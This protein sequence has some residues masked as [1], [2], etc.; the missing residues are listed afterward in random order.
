MRLPFNIDTQIN[1][2]Q[3]EAFVSGIILAED[4]LNMPYILSNYIRTVHYIDSPTVLNYYMD[5]LL[6]KNNGVINENLTVLPMQC[7][8]K[9]DLSAIAVKALNSGR[10]V[11]GSF[12][13]ER[14]PGKSSYSKRYFIHDYLLY[15]YENEA[16]ISSAYLSDGHYREFK[17][18]F[19]DYNRAMLTK[20]HGL[21]MHLLYYNRNIEY[22]FMEEYVIEAI[23]D[24]ITSKPLTDDGTIYGLQGIRLFADEIEKQGGYLDIRS[25]CFLNE[26]K[27][28]MRLRLSYMKEKCGLSLKDDALSQY[29]AMETSLR[30]SVMLAIKN[31]ATPS[32]A[33]LMRIAETVRSSALQDEEVLKEV[34]G[35]YSK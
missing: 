14:I 2:Y 1:T 6:L 5:N 3:P 9:I 13:D 22:E 32:D 15:G 23:R 20:E 7:A 17:I 19:N 25:L 4:Q 30:I 10:Y 24:Y 27:R 29:E 8:Q 26:H 28:L 34:L 11:F 21:Y 31:K 16:F 18:S 35:Q 33:I 12:N